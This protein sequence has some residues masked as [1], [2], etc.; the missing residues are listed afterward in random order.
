LFG[1]RNH[2]VAGVSFDGARSDFTASSTIGGLTTDTR[3]FI[4]PG[5]LIDEPGTNSPV[6]VA[7]DNA[8]YGIYFADTLNLTPQAALTLSGRY[9]N[10]QIDLHD[11]NGG[12]LSGSHSYSHFNPAAGLTYRFAPSLTLYAGYAVANRAPTPAELSCAGPENSCSLANFFV[13][14]PHLDQVIA[15]TMEAGVRGT[16]APFVGG[17]LSYE[18][19]FF[20]T[21]LDNEIAFINSV[22]QGRA[23]FANIG[24]TQRRGF[25]ARLQLVT[26]RW[27]A[28]AAYSYIQAR[29]RG[30]FVEG[31]GDN[32]E[33][34]PDGN[35]TV[36]SGDR[37]PGI[38]E[39]QFKVGAY[40]RL[41]DAWTLGLTGIASNGAYL[42]GDEANLT[43]RLPG[44]YT[45]NA[46]T[47]YQVTKNLQL[48]AWVNNFTNQKYYTF[49]TFSPTSSVFLVEAPNATNPR[50]YSPAAPIA[51]FIGVRLAY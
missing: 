32:P 43:P 8:T 38:P 29:F 11:Q 20:Q 5:V 23:F 31:S 24:Q 40:Y 51:G 37:L 9:N 1:L 19:G 36:Q 25:D 15:H 21:N 33:A 49:G 48:F 13:G 2:F 17:A 30:G 4:G 50:S 44:Y 42:F 41:S 28:Y 45:L 3:V 26:D 7:I 6:S 18:L 27:N 22:T 47:A 16:L 35:I 46:S 12:D 34:D 14:D 10:A 39:H